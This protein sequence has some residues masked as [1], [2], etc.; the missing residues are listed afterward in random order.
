M[1][2]HIP[3]FNYFRQ[4]SAGDHL[5]ELWAERRLQ[6]TAAGLPILFCGHSMA[7]S[8]LGITREREYVLYL[9]GS[10]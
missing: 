9:L 3:S 10:F 5:R 2:I 8:A 4:S 7:L 1:V 6:S